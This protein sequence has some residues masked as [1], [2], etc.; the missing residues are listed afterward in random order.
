MTILLEQNPLQM[1]QANMFKDLG[2][3]GKN[4][5]TLL[6]TSE[7]A[8]LTTVDFIKSDPKISVSI[9]FRL[10]SSEIFLLHTHIVG[11]PVFGF[12]SLLWISI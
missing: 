4:I 3:F 11:S 8:I 1:N 9:S 7:P 5:R 10:M 2:I 6:T 12:Q